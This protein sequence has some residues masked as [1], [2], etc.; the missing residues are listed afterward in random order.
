[1]STFKT[2]NFPPKLI[3]SLKN[4]SFNVL[5]ECKRNYGSH[6]AV[7]EL[8]W[9]INTQKKINSYM[10]TFSNSFIAT[11]RTAADEQVLSDLQATFFVD[12]Q[13]SIT[14]NAKI[15]NEL[16]YPKLLEAFAI[17]N[18]LLAENWNSS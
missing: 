11:R 10:K 4:Y 1:M 15:T 8:S 2:N 7:S 9:V 16:F 18:K 13:S 3:E 17:H 14:D 6:I 12:R 5:E